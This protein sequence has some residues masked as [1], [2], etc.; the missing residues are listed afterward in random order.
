MKEMAEGVFRSL[1]A[2][3]DRC[4]KENS[5]HRVFALN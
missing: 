5:K 1:V 2:L 3:N 4:I